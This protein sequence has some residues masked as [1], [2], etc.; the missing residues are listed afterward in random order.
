MK[1][2]IQIGILVQSVL[3]MLSFNL[4]KFQVMHGGL[5]KRDD[6]KLDELRTIDRNRQP[7][8]EGQY[9]RVFTGIFE[10]PHFASLQIEYF[11]KNSNHKVRYHCK[12]LRSLY[13]F[14][15]VWT[16]L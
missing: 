16:H 13:G 6:V 12:P 14:E 1:D 9:Q 7:G 4:H 10:F 15:F 3:T 5:F 8:E 11:M 2:A